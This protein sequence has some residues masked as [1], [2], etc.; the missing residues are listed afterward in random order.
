MSVESQC[1]IVFLTQIIYTVQFRCTFP[2]YKRKNC[3]KY[4]ATAFPCGVW[5]CIESV[6]QTNVVVV[7]VIALQITVFSSLLNTVL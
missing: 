4:I 3:D 6:T 1:V 5:N 2:K 7:I